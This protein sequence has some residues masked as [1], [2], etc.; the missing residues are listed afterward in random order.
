MNQDIALNVGIDDQAI[1]RQ[2]TEV[3]ATIHHA[4]LDD[5]EEI[6]TK[7]SLLE[8]VAQ[9]AKASEVQIHAAELRLHAERRLGEL[10]LTMNPGREFTPAQVRD[11]TRLARIPRRFRDRSM[12]RMEHAFDFLEGEGNQ[13]APKKTTPRYV[14]LFLDSV[15][16]Q[17]NDARSHT[18]Y[19]V[20]KASLQASSERHS[21]YPWLSKTWDDTWTFVYQDPQTKQHHYK[22][23]EGTID[24]VLE[25]R[26]ILSGRV[27]A[28]T[29]KLLPV[30]GK[31]P[32]ALVLDSVRQARE[33]LA[34]R[35]PDLSDAQKEALDGAYSNLDDL[36]S[37]V[38][39]AVN[40]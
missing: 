23:F 17:L 28:H 36:A 16:H 35:W 9:R 33:A 1:V 40:L 7:A 14:D 13:E 31:D 6:R 12:E 10:W 26:A 19:S 30:R 15:H 22:M 34:D 39:R 24:Q 8:V 20:Y 4:D 37:A 2:L 21:K 18:A 32:L 29:T 5:A 11:F 3:M 27:S 38:V 25:R